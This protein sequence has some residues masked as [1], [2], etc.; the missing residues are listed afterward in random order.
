MIYDFC[1]EMDIDSTDGRL[2]MCVCVTRALCVF[3]HRESGAEKR[4]ADPE[5]AQAERDELG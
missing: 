3:Q 1:N 5:S 4:G 2:C